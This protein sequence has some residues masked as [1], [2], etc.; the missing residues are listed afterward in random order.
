VLTDP[1]GLLYMAARYYNPYLCRFV[2]PDPKGFSGGLNFYAYT[3]GNPISLLDPFGLSFWSVTGHF[4][5]GAIIGAAVTAAVIIAA[6]EIAAAGAGA[7]IWAGVSEGTATVVASATVTSGLWV[8]GAT[9]AVTTGANV[10]QNA[11]AGNWDNVAFDTGGLAG[12]FLVGTT[13]G[14]LGESSGGRTLTDSLHELIGKPPSEAPDT[15][16]LADIYKYERDN[17]YDL[18]SRTVAI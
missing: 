5:E 11:K 8:G 16:N 17:E 3:N 15:W 4:L 14:I 13:P 12:G 7:L 6:P 18:T 1:N 2:N 9:G 10:I